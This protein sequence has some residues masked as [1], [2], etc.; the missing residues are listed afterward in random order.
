M[1]KLLFVVGMHGDEKTPVREVTGFKPEPNYLIANKMALKKGKRF[2]EKDL[3]R[4]F[5]G[6][7]N[8]CLEELLARKILKKIKESGA[9]E[10]IDVHSSSCP[11][12]PFVIIT[13]KTNGHLILAKRTGI[14][15]V[16]IMNKKIASGRALID[17]VDLGVSIEAGREGKIKTERVIRK[18]IEKLLVGKRGNTIELYKVF[19][20]LKKRSEREKLTRNVR[21]FVKIE[22]G[23]LI[24]REKNYKRFAETAF[25]PVLPRSKNYSGIFCLMAKKYGNL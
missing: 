19:G 16:I 6:A 24:S 9:S 1:K 5:P 20:V 21:P 12:P 23:E 8:G 15:R 2:L 25:Y 4:V 10:I 3:N 11:T 22:K 17:H 7:E 14:R 13:K 18:S